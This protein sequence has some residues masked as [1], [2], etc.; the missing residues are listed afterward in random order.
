[1]YTSTLKEYAY[2]VEYLE[3][4]YVMVNSEHTARLQYFVAI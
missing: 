2:N 1:M 4:A 3:K